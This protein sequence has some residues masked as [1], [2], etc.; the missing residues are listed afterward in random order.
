MFVGVLSSLLS[1]LL[2]LFFEPLL[3][4]ILPELLWLNSRLKSKVTIQF[5]VFIKQNQLADDTSF[6][7]W[8]FQEFELWYH[9]SA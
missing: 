5:D 4:V 9:P 3:V 6:A 8:L 1:M 2:S 7:G